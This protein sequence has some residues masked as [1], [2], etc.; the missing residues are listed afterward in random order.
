MANSTHAHLRYNI[1]D[2][3]FRKR[4]LTF[5]QLLKVVN[6]GIADYYPGDGISKR[7]LR[8]DLK[9]FRDEKNGFGAP[10]PD[11][12]RI[13][14]YTD[15]GFS[16]A[17]R[18]L[19]PF[20][21]YLIEASQELLKRF[22]NHPK[23]NKLSEALT[24][25]EDEEDSREIKDH[26]KILFYDKNE[27]YDGL[28]L[29][30][31][32]FLSIKKKNVLKITT[33]KFDGTDQKSFT[34]HPHILKQYN[35]RWYVFGL[36]SDINVSQWVVPLDDRLKSFEVLEDEDYESDDMDWDD[37]F[38]KMVGPTYNSI[39]QESPEL[40]H[41]V[42]RFASYRLPYFKSKPIHPLWDEFAEEGKENQVFFEAIINNE[43]VQQILSY[44]K[45]VEV[46]EPDSLKMKMKE[47][48]NTIQQYYN[49]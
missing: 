31:P 9:V 15:S 13:L 2:Y 14:K 28:N 43:L 21:Q 39:T 10:L 44:G 26:S 25:Y 20:E 48:A 24:L 1:L 4:S 16:I 40:E 49:E 18:S 45:D 35:Q 11:K 37:F 7:T 33:E 12:I 34:F 22:D 5:E 6:E 36:N 17:Q 46:L 23:Y 19:L 47:Q 27:A 30:R 32:L 3:C 29:L 8:D 38:R 41:I 42:L